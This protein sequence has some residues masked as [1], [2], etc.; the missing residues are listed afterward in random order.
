MRR[1]LLRRLRWAALAVAL[2]AVAVTGA[3]AYA[4]IMLGR[5]LAA[6]IA[7]AERTDPNWRIGDMMAHREP[8]ADAENGARVVTEAGSFLPR[9]WPIGPPRGGGP[10]PP[11]PAENALALIAKDWEPNVRFTEASASLLREAL[12]EVPEAVRVARTAANYRR[13]RHELTVAPL[14]IETPLPDTDNARFVAKLLSLDAALR[15]HEGDPDGA[16]RIVPRRRLRGPLDRRRT[17]PDL[18]AC[19]PELR[20][21]GPP[22]DLPDPGAGRAL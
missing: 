22:I 6:A 7:E 2:L 9:R 19:A 15:A 4:R 17:V 12:A 1:K 3:W 14:A 18:A 11:S 13:G 10:L 8:L 20:R 16:P 5:R 21:E